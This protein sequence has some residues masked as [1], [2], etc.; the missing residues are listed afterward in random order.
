MDRFL[1][2]SIHLP[3][4]CTID[5]SSLLLYLSFLRTKYPLLFETL[6]RN[7]QSTNHRPGNYP[8]GLDKAHL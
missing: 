1:E 6:F 2:F 7:I 4:I 3:V 8:N 5:K